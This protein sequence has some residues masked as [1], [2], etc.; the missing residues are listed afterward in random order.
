MDGW[1]VVVVGGGSAGCVLATRLA[2]AHRRVLLLE[3]GPVDA[4]PDDV[5][6]ARV[7]PARLGHP[8]TWSYPARLTADR[9]TR[10]VRGRILGG[11]SA[12]NG[13]Y[14]VRAT[15]TDLAELARVGGPAF[16]PAATTAAY[17]RS[18]T[19]HDVA[20]PGHGHDGPVPVAR[21]PAGQQHAVSRAVTAAALAAGVPPQPDLN[22][23]G[24]HGV[25]P[26]PLNVRDGVRV[27]TGLA[28]VRRAPA[29]LTV[30]G[31]AV[32]TR[33][34]TT[35][36]R[37]TGVELADGTRVDADEVVL[38]AGAL[39]TPALLARSGLGPRHVSGLS[40]HPELALTW[41]PAQPLDPARR[42]GLEV[43]VHPAGDE[44]ELRPYTA[45]F[46]ALVPGSGAPD[47]PALGVA[48]MA[49]R[50]RGTLT[51]GEHP[52]L[53]LDY[54]HDADD[55]AVLRDGVRLARELLHRCGLATAT[56]A[57]AVADG[58]DAALD[59]WVAERLGTS[60]HTCGTAALG[61]TSAA[62]VDGRLRLRGV[63]GVRVVDASVLPTVPRRGP[64]AT[65]VMLAELAATLA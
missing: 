59:R 47:V 19:D 5:L 42:A 50:G 10:V 58:P 11:S 39:A 30:R 15:T 64:H 25:G 3:A 56:D 53:D 57:D 61:T 16:S 21:T 24:A 28:Y 12:L 46:A 45:S 9:A 17:A 43:V 52:E 60:L 6:D 54:L 65:V 33:V 20:G 38:C 32:V 44:L 55:R 7:I 18:E 8:A 37:A 49:P 41:T 22:A 26:V 63:D 1:D 40:D 4:W 51:L 2:E 48:A 36:G 13:G 27:N 62:P 29:G 31:G 23:P 14:F 35:G 34:S